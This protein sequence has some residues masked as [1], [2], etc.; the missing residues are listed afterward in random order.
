MQFVFFC[1]LL[2]YIR[3]FDLGIFGPFQW[4]HKVKIGMICV[5]KL[6]PFRRYDTVEEDFYEQQVGCWGAYIIWIVDEVAAHRGS[7]PIWI[8]FLGSHVAHELDVS[9]IF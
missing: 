5:G 8:L 1:H 4:C 6:S 3:Q 9:Q 2:R 7:C